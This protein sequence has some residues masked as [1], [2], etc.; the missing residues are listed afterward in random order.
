M[1]QLAIVMPS[2]IKQLRQERG[3]S[4]EELADRAGTTFSTI[5]K[6]EASTRKLDLEWID[7]LAAAFGISPFDMMTGVN[8]NQARQIP[9]LGKIAAGDWREA[10]ADPTGY[11]FATLGGS[12]AFAL[13]PDGDSMDQLVPPGGW[14][15]IDPDKNELRDGKAYAVMNADGDTTFKRFRTDPARLEPCSSNPEH[16]PI[17]LGQEP[18]KVIGM[19]VEQGSPL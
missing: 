13:Y 5:W 3:W 18:F 16:Q 12:N 8:L 6:L 4:L 9:V 19:A 10:L 17:I 11:V 2:R 1:V 14:V 15:V 7:R